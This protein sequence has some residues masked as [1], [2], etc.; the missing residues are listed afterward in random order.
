MSSCLVC[1]KDFAENVENYLLTCDDCN[2]SWHHRCHQ[3]PVPDS[4]VVEMWA[5]FLKSNHAKLKWTCLKCSRRK[6][7]ATV[8]LAQPANFPTMPEILDLDTMGS[9]TSTRRTPEARSNRM[10]TV[11]EIIDLTESPEAR[12]STRV[13]T[14]RTQAAEIIDLSEIP[15]PAPLTPSHSVTAKVIDLSLDSPELVPQKLPELPSTDLPLPPRAASLPVAVDLP[16]MEDDPSRIPASSRQPTSKSPSLSELAH[17]DTPTPP[18]T[19]NTIVR[20]PSMDVDDDVDQKPLFSLLQK[21]AV[22]DDSRGALLDLLGCANVTKLAIIWRCGNDLLKN[23]RYR[24]R[25]LGESLK[26]RSLSMTFTNRLLYFHS[27]IVNRIH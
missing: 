2:R 5:D 7:A 3:P 25:C 8:P 20:F 1:H 10:T 22:S 17:P 14:P 26:R 27:S 15:P 12:R 21:L 18:S 16:S 9:T 11:S 19:P 6:K 4:V 13:H 24:S 23:R